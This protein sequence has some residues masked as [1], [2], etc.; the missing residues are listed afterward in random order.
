MQ[1]SENTNIKSDWWAGN[2]H[3]ISAFC[4]L[5]GHLFHVLKAVVFDFNRFSRALNMTTAEAS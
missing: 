5:Q 4:F 3:F 1:I 2:A